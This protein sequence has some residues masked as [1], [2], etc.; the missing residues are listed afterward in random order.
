MSQL[1][2]SRRGLNNNL[3]VN[4]AL[5]SLGIAYRSAAVVAVTVGRL[6][7]KLS[8]TAGLLNKSGVRRS[9]LNSVDAREP[10]RNSSRR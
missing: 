4:Y 6:I 3:E 8:V 5:A 2:R 7:K 9:R 10:S 1:S